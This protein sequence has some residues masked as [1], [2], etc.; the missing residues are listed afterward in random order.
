MRIA[1]VACC[2]QKLD[3][4]APAGEL[5]TSPLFRKAASYARTFDRW[6]ILSAK[7]GLLRPDVVVEPYD[8]TLLGMRKVDRLAWGRRVFDQMTT[9]GIAG[10]EFVALAGAKY[11]EP[12]VRVGLPVKT[13]LKGLGIGQQLA[14][15]TKRNAGAVGG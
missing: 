1:L 15:L 7:H 4:A 14:W 10:V 5:Y 2:G 8:C 6:Y 12:L 9:E 3:R 13:P 11:T